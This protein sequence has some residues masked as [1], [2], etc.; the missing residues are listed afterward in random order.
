MSENKSFAELSA[1]RYSVRSFETKHVE[2]EKIEKILAVGNNAPTACN[3]QP[4]RI[5]VINTPDAL[6]KLRKCT[7]SHF[8]CTLAMLV[9]YD[10][11][12]CWTRE[13]DGAKSGEVDASII[14]TH[15]MLA[16]WEL[17]IG[18][19][20]VMHFIPEAI[21]EEFNLPPHFRPVSLLVMGYPS[22]TAMPSPHHSVKKESSETVFFNTFDRVKR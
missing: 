8:D 5:L 13:Y 18:S 21:C 20:W 12:E 1:E 11:T 2:Q 15:L 14:T 7:L 3:R 6:A 22:Q 17:G 16:A 10:E 9:C 4:Q 19:T